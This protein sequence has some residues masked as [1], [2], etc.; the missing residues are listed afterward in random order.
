MNLHSYNDVYS[1]EKMENDLV[2]SNEWKKRSD[3]LKSNKTASCKDAYFEAFMAYKP[4]IEKDGDSDGLVE[5]ISVWEKLQ[6]LYQKMSDTYKKAGEF[7]DEFKK[8]MNEREKIEKERKRLEEIR[9]TGFVDLGLPS[10]TLWKN[11]NNEGGW[12]NI[13]THDQI[14]FLKD[15]IPTKEQCEELIKNCQWVWNGDGYNIIG[16][17]SET[18]F[19]P[20]QEK[21]NTTFYW[22]RTNTWKLC[23]S[24]KYISLYKSRDFYGLYPV[25][26]VKKGE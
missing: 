18:M 17:N 22:T 8:N 11:H 10:K 6:E 14:I 5:L 15:S 7:D 3:W 21:Y 13:F 1:L 20:V 16:K 25:R 2:M 4:M 26:I 19:L 23:I 9:K 24:Q 12:N